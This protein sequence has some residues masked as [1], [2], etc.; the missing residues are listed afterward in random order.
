ML[1]NNS[2]DIT[3]LEVS[4]RWDISESIPFIFIK[5][6][7][8]G[9][10]L[11]NM[12]YAFVAKSPSG[13]FIHNGDINTPDKSGIWAT[14]TITGGWPIPFNQI[15]WSGADYEMYVVAKDGSGNI[16]TT[17]VQS[18]QI[19]RPV[20]NT[21]D[22]KNTFGKAKSDVEVKCEMA[23]VFFQDT[24]YHTYRGMTGER[25]Y[26][27]LKVIY[28]IDE[29]ETVPAPFSI[30]DYSTALIP[31]SYSAAN[32]QYLQKTIYDYDLGDNVTIRVRYQ[33]IETFAVW[34]NVDLNP[35]VC[36]FNRLIDS[37]NN[38]TCLDVE[39]ANKKLA[40]IAPKMTLVFIGKMQPMTGINVPNL[41]EEIKEIGSFDI[42][43]CG[44]NTG[45]IPTS[46]SIIDGY[47]FVV[48]GTG[49]VTGTST[50]NG[51]NIVFNIG[52]FSYI[53]T[54][55]NSSPS[56]TSAFSFTPSQTGTQKTYALN[57]DANQ[58]SYD[59][60]NQIKG[61]A[62]LVNFFNSIVTTSGSKLLVDG[63]CLFTTST[64]CDYTFTILGV[65]ANTSFS[66]LTGIN[67][68]TL[69]FAFNQ[70]NLSALQT[71]LNGLNLGT[72][73]V[74]NQ[75]GG[76]VLISSSANT[77]NLTSLTYNIGS[78]SFIANMT[79][80]CLGYTPI[81]ASEAVQNLI[82]FLCG[83]KDSDIETSK[84][85]SVCYID[86]VTNTKKTVTVNSG[87]ALSDF[88]TELLARGCNTIDYVMSLGAVT[89]ASIVNKFPS[90]IKVLQS[91]D[92]VLGVKEGLCARILPIELVTR[93]FELGASDSRFM[94]AVC[95]VVS[96]CG[97]GSVCDPF[98]YFNLTVADTSPSS[99]SQSL[100]LDFDH[101]TATKYLVRY[102]RI[103]NTSTPSYIT[104][105][106][107]MGSPYTIPSV[108]DGQYSVGIT[109]QYADN[110]RCPELLKTTTSCSGIFNFSAVIGGSPTGIVISYTA[111][112]S[113][114]NIRVLVSYPNGGSFSQ[115][116][117]N[118]GNPINI[119]PPSGVYGDYSITIQPVC[120]ATTGYYGIP[121]AP[122]VVNVID[123]YAPLP[124]P[125]KIRTLEANNYSVDMQLVSLQIDGTT[126][127]LY[128]GGGGGLPIPIGDA[129]WSNDIFLATVTVYVQWT[130]SV[131]G[132]NITVLDSRGNPQCVPSGGAG[133]SWPFTGIDNTGPDPIRI[134]LQNGACS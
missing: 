43:C 11:A 81:S 85:Y 35:L 31:I 49:D 45:I 22:S 24:T 100:I 95:N 20:G 83:I 130:N 120:N 115:V 132:Q 86:T 8:T 76:S 60:L 25:V 44:A 51:S 4:V 105:P 111:S 39:S 30:T 104:I 33:S 69:N 121:T 7:S 73:V 108:P 98:N 50:K 128:G 57:V 16:F 106:N 21:K 23:R 12:S 133:G 26:S 56:N 19:C 92:Y 52:D 88:I 61:D 63:K 65:P 48:N 90:S 59:I 47:N 37:V 118:D 9:S 28:P 125:T 34:C 112:E 70:T 53:V 102:A 41:I 123:P 38:G 94:A 36:E 97:A 40:L 67:S 119:N 46:S 2:P 10:G 127:S 42:N 1:I 55:N 89:C 134:T 29:T 13:T 71:Y 91:N 87:A 110:R 18:A 15:E 96:M 58:L 107:V 103:D 68:Q 32:Y 114:A 117:T 78:S 54:V 99:N 77:K 6:K 74:T 129:R 64:S 75:G 126:P 72:F 113:L 5:N 79:R 116:Y 131:G 101:P 62:A 93:V 122:V 27:S 3:K 84:N 124:V 80:D 82:D 66:I 14:H 17:P 109:P